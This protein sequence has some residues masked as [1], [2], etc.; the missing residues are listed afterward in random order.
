MA[1]DKGQTGKCNPIKH[2]NFWFSSKSF[3]E[4]P[5]CNGNMKR[6]TSTCMSKEQVLQTLVIL[7]LSGNEIRLC[8]G[9]K[10]IVKRTGSRR[11]LPK[12]AEHFWGSRHPLLDQ[13]P[14]ELE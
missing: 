7:L 12:T 6:R 5:S 1:P 8:H 10:K 14:K 3:L 11:Y 9:G 4:P 13:P 2:E